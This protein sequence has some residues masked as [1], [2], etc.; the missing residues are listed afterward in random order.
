MWRYEGNKAVEG[1]TKR[2]EKYSRLLYE[3]DINYT[4]IKIILVPSD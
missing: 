2:G 4:V 3:T 1:L